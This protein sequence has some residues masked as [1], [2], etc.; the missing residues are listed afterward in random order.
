MKNIDKQTSIA[1]MLYATIDY[2]EFLQKQ[3]Q[4]IFQNHLKWN[5]Y[6]K[7]IALETN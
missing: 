5:F 6:C 2:I 3:V 1:N 4:E 7:M